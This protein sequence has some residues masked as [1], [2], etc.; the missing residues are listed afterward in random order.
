MNTWTT[1]SA[2]TS[3]SSRREGVLP[4]SKVGLAVPREPSLSSLAASHS[5]GKPDGG[6]RSDPPYLVGQH[7]L[8]S[9]ATP[10][11]TA[12][13]TMVEIAL[14]L[15][16]IAFALVAIIGVLPSGLKV[17]RENREDTIV[18]QDASYLLEAIRSGS[19]G[20]D[21]L[22]NY[23]ESITVRRGAQRWDYTNN[24]VNPGGLLPLTNGQQIIALLS[25][26]KMERGPNNTFRFNTITARMRAISGSAIEKGRGM[27]DFA[28][29]YQVTAEVMGVTNSWGY[30]SPSLKETLRSAEL[31]QNLY[32]VRLVMRWPLF[33]KGN[34]W[35]V[36][37]YRRTVRTL[38]SG[39]LAN[40]YTNASG[41]SPNLYLFE[42]DTFVSYH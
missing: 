37:R 28:F 35:D 15:G 8:T 32:D 22:T 39:Q 24:I 20:V 26:P 4:K 36:G 16:I 29:R 2:A 19:R 31:S 34:T 7:A 27:A 13:F 12:A 41:S 38:V 1:K 17:Q 42:P 14:C 6:R 21:E 30:A 23:V 3:R 33:Q 5:T 18:N 10:R 40:V 11:G 9:V 25:T